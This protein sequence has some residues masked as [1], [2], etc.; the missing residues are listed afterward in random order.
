MVRK[1]LHLRKRDKIH[2][3]IQRNG[4]VLITKAEENKQDP[5]ISDFLAFISNETTIT[6]NTMIVLING[7]SCSGKSTI[8]AQVQ[9]KLGDG[10]LYFSMDAYLSM[11]GPKFEGL[12]PDNLEV[13]IPNDICYAK[14]HSD[15]TYEI[16]LGPL[17]TRL[18]DT[19]PEVLILMAEQGFNIIV[20]SVISSMDEFILYKKKLEKYG[21]LCVY[22][23]ASEKIITQRE[24]ERGDRLK[25]SAIHWLKSFECASACDLICNTEDGSINAI[26]N[27][28]IQKI[29]GV[30][31]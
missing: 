19:I 26:S 31:V 3:I 27:E 8:S 17:C 25:G 14:K 7:T 11:L 23:Y 24:A 5:V 13:C 2:Y 10:W 15:G 18:N 29:N 20:D 30:R 6:G 16:K 9:E 1:A 21:L 28:I 12:H 22:L 4:G